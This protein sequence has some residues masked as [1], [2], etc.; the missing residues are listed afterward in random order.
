M[1]ALERFDSSISR[2]HAAILEMGYSPLVCTSEERM[3]RS[4]NLLSSHLLTNAFACSNATSSLRVAI[5]GKSSTIFLI[6][7]PLLGESQKSKLSGLSKLSPWSMDQP[8]RNCLAL[9]GSLP[10]TCSLKPC[11]MWFLISQEILTPTRWS[12]PIMPQKWQPLETTRLPY[13]ARFLT[14]KPTKNGKWRTSK[15]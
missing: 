7:L 6:P 3:N 2:G 12:I 4:T 14:N 13:S 11:L 5:L 15:N 1:E 9:F 8:N 10:R